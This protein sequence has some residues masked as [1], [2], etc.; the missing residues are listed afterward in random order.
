MKIIFAGTPDFSVPTLQAL[1][2]SSHDICAA[3]TQ[4]DR[5][6]GRGQ[7]IQIS[8]VKKCALEHGLAI[9]QPLNFK[10]ADSLAA[11]KAYKAD[12]MVV[13]AYGIILPE[14]VLNIPTYG[15]INIHASLLPRWRGAAP[16]QRAILAGDTETGVTLMQMDKGLDT[17]DMLSKSSCLIQQNSTSSTLHDQLSTLGADALIKLLPNIESRR[18]KPIQQTQV[19]ATYAKKFSKQDAL[20]DWNQPATNIHRAIRAYNPWPVSHTLLEDKSLRIWH[21]NLVEKK[22]PDPPGTLNVIG[23]QVFVACLDG[24]LEITEL[25]AANKRKMSTADYLAAHNLQGLRLG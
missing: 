21:A 11:L 24:Q 3:Y 23:Q 19:D 4:P 12:L 25:Q 14:D 16:I 17:G 15:C 7:K 2:S 5:P 10:N 22:S 9:E 6:A 20:I 18:L 8:S 13:V 1:L